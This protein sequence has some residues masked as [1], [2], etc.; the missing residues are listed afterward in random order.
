MSNAELIP[1]FVKEARELEM[2][3]FKEFGVYG[4]VPRSHQVHT[5]EKIIGVR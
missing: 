5:G 1:K 2:D 3:Y 4:R